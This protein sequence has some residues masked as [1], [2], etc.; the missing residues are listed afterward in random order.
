M[1]DDFDPEGTRLPIKIDSTSNGEWAPVPLTRAA[2]LGNREA[3]ADA[4]RLSRKL[5]ISR[6]QF[7]VSAAGA[8]A[9]LLAFNRAHAQ[10]G[11]RGGFFELPQV[12]ALD[13]H[14]AQASVGGGEF[15][16]DVQNHCVDP[17]ASWRESTD[18][19]RWNYILNNLFG[20]RQKCAPGLLDAYSAQQ[21]LKDVYLDSDTQIGV[22]TA[23]WG[24]RGGNPTSIDYAKEAQAVIGA[25]GSNKRALIHGGVM[26]NEP[27]GL[28]F[29]DVQ[30]KEY[31][32][33]AWKLYPQWGPKGVGFYMDDEQFGIPFVEKVRASGIKIVCAHRGLPLPFLLYEYSDPADIARVAARYPD[34]TFICYHSG[35]EPGVREGVYNPAAPAGV[36]RLIKA[37]QE[38][39]FTRNRGNLYAELGGVW[40]FNMR[41]PE[42]AAHLMGKLLKYFGEDRICWGTDSIWFGSPQDQIQAFRTFQITREFQDKYGYPEITPLMRAKI[43][44]LNAAGPYRLDVDQIKKEAKE[45]SIGTLKASYSESANPSFQSYGP[46][47]AAEYRNLLAES[48]GRPG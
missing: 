3:F 27:G 46:K 24:A 35:F 47:T 7:L 39:G 43:F 26:P 32:V 14:A 9:T 15:I 21:L 42:A 36:D 48:N 29:M 10:S 37:H 25:M 8:A 13:N 34:V 4:Q 23:L 30:A 45:D 28:E 19:A 44:G 18:G 40:M 38:S 20:Q 11:A 2:E 5:N 6:R 33:A 1:L 17:S 41:D 22:V 31:K 16:F 12:A